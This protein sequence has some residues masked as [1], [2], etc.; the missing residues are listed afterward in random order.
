MYKRGFESSANYLVPVEQDCE[1]VADI[2]E[3]TQRPGAPLQ[4]VYCRF[5][6]KAVAKL[7]SKG[8]GGVESPEVRLLMEVRR[9][10]FQRASF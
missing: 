5:G 10:S 2:R 1:Q 4:S 3:K 9:K 8:K 6:Q 7:Q